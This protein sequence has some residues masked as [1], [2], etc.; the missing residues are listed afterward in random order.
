VRIPGWVPGNGSAARSEWAP[1]VRFAAS[2]L[3]A[4]HP[5][6]NPL[7][8]YSQKRWCGGAL[9]KRRRHR[10]AGAG[11]LGGSGPRPAAAPYAVRV[12]TRNPLS[13]GGSRDGVFRGGSGRWLGRP[14]R[15]ASAQFGSRP[16]LDSASTTP[17]IRRVRVRRN[18]V[19]EG[20]SE[21]PETPRGGRG[22]AGAK[23]KR[24]AR[25]PLNGGHHAHAREPFRGSPPAPADAEPMTPNGK[26]P[27][28]KGTAA[29]DARVREGIRRWRTRPSRRAAAESPRPS[30]A[31]T[32]SAR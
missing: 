15:A 6:R 19:S 25:N 8:A 27:P 16:P 30:D 29:F 23:I 9:P 3:F 22:G 2:A 21:T 14:R 20:T 12:T 28:R 32:N 17:G 11:R 26:R 13:S 31:G 1:R 18:E 7:R 5:T 4:L 10:E 24:S